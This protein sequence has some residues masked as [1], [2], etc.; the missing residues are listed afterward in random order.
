[1]ANNCCS[2]TAT[3]TSA[4]TID[5]IWE[6]SNIDKSDDQED[7][8]IET[9]MRNSTWEIDE[10]DKESC[11]HL[12]NRIDLTC[13]SFSWLLGNFIDLVVLWTKCIGKQR[14][15]VV[16]DTIVLSCVMM[17][18]CHQIKTNNEVT[19]IEST[20]CN[21]PQSCIGN[22]CIYQTRRS[23]TWYLGIIQS[24]F[25]LEEYLVVQVF[26][27]VGEVSK[28]GLPSFAAMNNHSWTFSLTLNCYLSIKLLK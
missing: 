4:L 3:E 24:L 1:M 17:E 10:D 7:C 28:R 14:L 2:L 19:F 22:V 12:Q 6:K 27:W 23:H 18:R 15:F 21:F 16:E 9:D 26:T 11:S 13:D 20:L 5:P 8:V 25:L